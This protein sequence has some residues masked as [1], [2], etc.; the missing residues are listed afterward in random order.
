MDVNAIIVA[1]GQ[2]KR[3]GG[4]LPKP[5]LTLGGR[6][7][8]LHTLGRFAASRV[9]KVIV[10]VPAKH[11]PQFEQ[12]I[13]WDSGLSRLQCVIQPG[14]ATRQDSVAQ[15]LKM[16]DK[17][18]KIAVVHDGARPLISPAIIDRCVEIALDD[19][20]VVVGVRVRDTIKVVSPSRHVESTPG[21]ETLWE[22]QTPQV[23]R[24]EILRE[25][26]ESAERDGVRATDDAMLVERLGKSVAVLEGERSNLKITTPEDLLLAEALLREEPVV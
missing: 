16:L 25:A 1:A 18:C 24:A 15:G 2:G 19:G 21:R 14:G 10:V 8:I 26:Y 6:L 17:D 7:M 11:Q 23:F 3:M 13:S 12:V 22:I 4:D 20:A 9:R 5:L